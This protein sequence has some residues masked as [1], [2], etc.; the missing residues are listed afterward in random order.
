MFAQLSLALLLAGSAA[1]QVVRPDDHAVLTPVGLWPVEGYRVEKPP[2]IVDP[3]GTVRSCPER[4]GLLRLSDLSDPHG[5]VTLTG[6][7]PG[8]AR[9]MLGVGTRACLVTAWRSVVDGFDVDWMSV[10]TS[11]GGNGLGPNERLH[12]FWGTPGELEFNPTLGGCARMPYM[13]GPFHSGWPLHL[14][15]SGNTAEGGVAPLEFEQ[16]RFDG[17]DAE[18]PI[19]CWRERQFCRV[20]LFVGGRKYVHRVTSWFY[21]P[22]GWLSGQGMD[23]VLASVVPGTVHVRG[24]MFDDAYF[25]DLRT[26]VYTPLDDPATAADEWSPAP[27][28]EL[29]CRWDAWLG[30]LLITN[31]DGAQQSKPSPIASGYAASVLRRS[32]DDFCVA[33][34]VRLHHDSQQARRPTELHILQSLGTTPVSPDGAISKH[35]DECAILAEIVHK[36][37]GPGRA[38]GWIGSS[39]F[40][41]VGPFALAKSELQRLMAQGLL[42]AAPPRGLPVLGGVLPP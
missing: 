18:H 6:E 25:L 13:Q 8:G 38:K 2:T 20:E 28:V 5:F 26:G 15:W 41:Y 31:D 19:L 27:G 37:H 39:F 30:G 36:S 24:R 34:A 11:T 35:L 7:H 9:H 22:D 21:N 1:A 40:L 16:W 3:D 14:R 12:A 42:D 23:P 10:G 33:C 29:R 32:S 17:G 4:I